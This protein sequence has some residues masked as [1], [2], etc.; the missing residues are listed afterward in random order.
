[1]K[2]SAPTSLRQR[3]RLFLPL[4]FVLVAALVF[5]R[6]DEFATGVIQAFETVLSVLLAITFAWL[7][8]LI[9]Y[10]I[11]SLLHLDS[12][13][14]PVVILLS[15]I[16]GLG[17]L[18]LSLLV[19]VL[20]G[21]YK[22]GVMIIALLAWA[23]WSGDVITPAL[24]TLGRAWNACRPAPLPGRLY[25]T[26]LLLLLM[27]LVLMSL[28][29]ALTPA[30]SYDAL[31]EHLPLPMRLLEDGG[32]KPYPEEWAINSPAYINLVFGIGLGVGDSVFPRLIHLFLGIL[33]VFGTGVL[34]RQLFGADSFLP[35]MITIAT[36]PTL[37][38]FL[39]F[40]YID[41]GWALFE[42]GSIMCYFLWDETRDER[43]LFLM[44]S[45][46]GF[47]AGTK[48][49]GL[50]IALLL[51]A[52]VLLSH[53]RSNSHGFLRT[54]LTIV[55]PAFIIASPWYLKNWA[56]LG[57]PVFPWY[58]GGLGW[59]QDRTALLASYAG[60]FGLG[61]SLIDVLLIPWRLY[62]HPAAFGTVLKS[63]DT[64]GLLMPLALLV[65]FFRRDRR[66]LQILLLTFSRA[67]LW[68]LATQQTRFL[69][70]VYPLIASAA[71][72]VLN[73]GMQRLKSTWLR[74][75][76]QAFMLGAMTVVV[77]LNA[78]VLWMLRP[79][80][81]LLGVETEAAFLSRT[82]K[83][84]P[85]YLVVQETYSADNPVVMLGDARSY[86]CHPACLPDSD[87]YQRASELAAL[88]TPDAVRMW[89]QDTGGQSLFISNEDLPFLIEHDR[90]GVYQPAL[91]TIQRALESGILEVTYEDT[92]VTIMGIHIEPSP[93]GKD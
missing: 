56:M 39:S 70:P 43:L 83:P 31:K 55:I 46:L 18:C 36:V 68:A 11:L 52:A 6:P 74:S 20:A 22:P 77:V 25:T 16:T 80:G 57:N 89:L 8:G 9:G 48:Y 40:A 66:S 72:F 59:D 10:K 84:Y 3:L 82:I 91:E 24:S 28:T 71:G 65:P 63:V 32:F 69:L 88:Q 42:L 75:L 58:F 30:W 29:S 2:T 67:G 37:P 64:P 90:T 38:T 26:L 49:T 85:A 54:V 53:L 1:M 13:D 61:T 86:Y 17:S 15:F 5:P 73:E 50:G 81:V 14:P 27:I 44:S 7:C 21:I 23:F 79:V 62:S 47:A 19:L 4:A 34:G 93:T 87:Q 33:L 51:G 41:A 12:M 78:A 45:L 35:A 76:P 92:W 60:S